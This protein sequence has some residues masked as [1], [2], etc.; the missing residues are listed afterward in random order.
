M[1]EKILVVVALGAIAL[2]P[3]PANAE[4]RYE[5]RDGVL[6]V[7][8][9]E[10][11]APAVAPATGARSGAPYGDVIREAA[12]RHSV[13]VELV[14]S[15][16]RVESNF[17]PRAVSRKGARGLMQL[18]PDTARLLGVE[19]TFDVRQNIEGGTRHLRSLMDR[20]RGNV[21]L[22]LAAYNAGAEAVTRYGGIPPYAET[23]AY[24]TRIL[25]LLR[26]AG[27]AD[28]GDPKDAAALEAERAAAQARSLHVYETADGRTVYSN[29]PPNKLSGTVREMLD[30][31]AQSSSLQ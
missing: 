20:Y 5:E 8:N 17:E 15:V 13:A 30:R 27:W 3:S 9:V 22:V 16:I 4:L 10:R 2:L 6:Y 19:N 7:K 29:L 26:R 28:P 31:R 25:G 1:I 21:P 24:V 12:E 14:E 23:Q 11:P 18:M